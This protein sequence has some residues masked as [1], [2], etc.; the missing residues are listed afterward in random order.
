MSLKT[1]TL[2]SLIGIIASTIFSCALYFYQSIMIHQMHQ[3][4]PTWLYMVSWASHTLFMNGSIILFLWVLF[5]KQKR[6]E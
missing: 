5:C 1:A 4:P 2:I 6:S 3:P